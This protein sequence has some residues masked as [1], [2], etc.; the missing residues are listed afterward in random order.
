MRSAGLEGT[1]YPGW[2]T[3]TT[4]ENWTDLEPALAAFEHDG[5][6]R[7]RGLRLALMQLS[8]MNIYILIIFAILFATSEAEQRPCEFIIKYLQRLEC[9]NGK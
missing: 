6:G 8:G 3:T 5:F 4:T 7:V 1:D 9:Y 2:S